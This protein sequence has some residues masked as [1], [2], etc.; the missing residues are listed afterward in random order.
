MAKIFDGVV[1]CDELFTQYH[2]FR[3]G[4][5][6][7]YNENTI[8]RL[9]KYYRSGFVSNIAQYERC[10]VNLDAHMKKQY[11]RNDQTQQSLEELAK[12][13]S[14]YKIILSDKLGDF[15]YVNILSDAEKIDVSITSSYT[16]KEDRRK[17]I[18]HIA[19][20]CSNAKDIILFD[21][22]LNSEK[23]KENIKDILNKIL[24]TS[25][26]VNVKC[27][28]MLP[29]ATKQYLTYCAPLR[30]FDSLGVNRANDY[31]DR[32]IIVDNKVE[33]LLSS[34]F[35]HL[36]RTVSDLTYVVRTIDKSRFGFAGNV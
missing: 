32:Y 33:I 20:I 7:S 9:L 24:P 6:E 15:P 23:E 22:H 35:D 28:D 16:L 3:E 4:A 36:A 19:S 14:L 34:G 31:H 2:A 27:Y 1:L 17:A 25:H 10:S 29:S 18:S 12:T 8:K 30:S 26:K 5:V 21:K 11:Y 13:H